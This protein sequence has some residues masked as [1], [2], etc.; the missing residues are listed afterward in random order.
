MIKRAKKQKPNKEQRQQA[1]LSKLVTRF[2][3][4]NKLSI[5]VVP[6]CK[7]N[8]NHMVQINEVEPDKAKM[9]RNG[10]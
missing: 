7:C 6:G 9:I 8:V 1:K 4:E 10:V 2:F 3:Q 5:T